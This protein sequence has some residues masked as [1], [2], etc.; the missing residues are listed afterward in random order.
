MLGLCEE[1]SY[2]RGAECPECGKKGKFL[3]NE[4]ETDTIGR[5]LAG[6]LRHFPDKFEL[7]MDAEGWVNI[8]DMV[9]AV[10]RTR[11]RMRWLK[12]HHFL[13]MVETDEK[14]RFRWKG[15]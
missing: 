4:H 2:Y 6:I 12:P 15:T 14:G 13:G 5:L 1:H 3:M 10:K 9:G 8:Y 11:G 7:Y